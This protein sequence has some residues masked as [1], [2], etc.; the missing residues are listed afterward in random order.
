MD[1]GP[2]RPASENRRPLTVAASTA[3]GAGWTRGTAGTAESATQRYQI[4]MG[5]V[6]P[7]GWDH[8]GQDHVAASHRRVRR[9]PAQTPGDTMDVCVDGKGRMATGEEQDA[10][11]RLVS[12]SLE[13]GQVATS[14]RGRHP[15]QMTEAQMSTIPPHPL[16]DA[17][18]DTT[19]RP[20]QPTRP[21]GLLDRP[22]TGP[23]RPGP[24]RKPTA[25]LDVGTI[26]VSIV[27]VLRQDRQDQL[28]QR[29]KAT[30]GTR[31][32]EGGLQTIEG[33]ADAPRRW[34]AARRFHD[35]PGEGSCVNWPSFN[36]TSSPVP[37]APSEPGLDRVKLWPS[38][39]YWSRLPQASTSIGA[40]K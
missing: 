16:E 2:G 11:D 27:R 21:N 4:D 9:N 24:G 25:Q 26:A 8:L 39:W 20:G 33:A 31:P 1:R 18:D 12:H 34:R 14:L 36:T 35:F 13:A 17:M 28:V 23:V 29:V 22:R 40:R 3:Q 19:L 6:I 7:P 10:A 38:D 30:L 15:T 37:A 5:G 32:S